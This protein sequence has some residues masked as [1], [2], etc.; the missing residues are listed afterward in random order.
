M[1]YLLKW[2][3][4]VP[5]HNKWQNKDKYLDFI[6]GINKFLAK[7][8]IDPLP[9]FKKKSK[10]ILHSFL[11]NIG[12][13]SKLLLMT[14]AKKIIQIYLIYS[15]LPRKQNLPIAFSQATTIIQPQQQLFSPSFP[16]I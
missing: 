1:Q 6:F 4:Y 9:A 10:A 3:R 7:R 5:K 11:Q 12:Q 16:H 2:K 14:M 8:D 15:L 13:G